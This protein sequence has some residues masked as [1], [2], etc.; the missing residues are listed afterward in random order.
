MATARSPSK[1]WVAREGNLYLGRATEIEFGAA[2]SLSGSFATSGI[3]VTAAVKN[4]TI[5]PPETGWEKQ[6]FM[7]KDSNNFQNQLLDEKPVGIATI[8]GTMILGEDETIEDYVVSGT[9]TGTSGY[10]RYQIGNGNTSINDLAAC[11]TLIS[12]NTNNE[13]SFAADNARLTK[14]GDVRITGPDAHWEQDFT[15]ICL[16]KDFYY[17]FKD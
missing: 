3:S 8:T 17:E 2:S 15:I 10:T 12:N 1:T 5:T 11:V 7:G 14:W 13:V 16:A 9:V 4:I 6:D